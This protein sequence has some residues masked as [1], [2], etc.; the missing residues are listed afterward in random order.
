MIG[1]SV[2]AEH[3][4]QTTDFTGVEKLPC[5]TFPWAAREGTSASFRCVRVPVL[6]LTSLSA[7]TYLA[8]FSPSMLFGVLLPLLS[9][10]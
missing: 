2:N 5:K 6:A 9:A 1:C 4:S 3:A 10:K 8:Y 7:S